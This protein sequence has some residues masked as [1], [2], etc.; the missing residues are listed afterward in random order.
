MAMEARVAMRLSKP[1]LY[2]LVLP[3]F[4]AC[5]LTMKR[6]Q[7]RPGGAP[8][9]AAR[10][11]PLTLMLNKQHDA[12]NL[13][14]E[15]RGSGT[16]ACRAFE[17]ARAADMDVLSR[18]GR[19]TAAEVRERLPNPPSYSAVRALLRTLEEKGHIKHEQDGPRYVFTPTVKRDTA[20]RSALR[21]VINTFFDGS[22]SQAM[23]ALVDLSARGINEAE[24]PGSDR[25][26]PTQK[27]GR[28]DWSWRLASWRRSPS[29][30]RSS[31]WGRGPSPR[32]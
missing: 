8:R 7:F 27:K 10:F 14:A 15:G 26:S 19:A 5:A 2:A 23:T 24:P 29:R 12:D 13:P 21:H 11:S 17:P 28:S 18:D 3:G 6:S 30:P 22:L 4:A 16:N 1:R 32:R 25:S 20:K 9:G 31:C